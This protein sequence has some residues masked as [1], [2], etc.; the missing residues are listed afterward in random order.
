VRDWAS[1]PLG[2]EVSAAQF[3]HGAAVIWDTGWGYRLHTGLWE[4]TAYWSRALGELIGVLEYC[5]DF[6]GVNM[7]RCIDIAS[8]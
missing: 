3:T 2:A 5:M 8:F 4:T 7:E 6:T 1:C